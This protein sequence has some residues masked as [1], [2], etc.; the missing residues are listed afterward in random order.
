MLVGFYFQLV[1]P[2]VVLPLRLCVDV[3]VYLVG[4]ILYTIDCRMYQEC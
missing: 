4:Y 3:I 2:Y 1:L